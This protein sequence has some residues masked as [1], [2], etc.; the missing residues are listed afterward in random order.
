MTGYGTLVARRVVA[1]WLIDNPDLPVPDDYGP[2][3]IDELV[4]RH[5]AEAAAY[6]APVLRVTEPLRFTP[7]GDTTWQATLHYD[8]AT[9]DPSSFVKIVNVEV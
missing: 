1:G 6:L 4:R 7:A 5:L 8:W 9:R 3:I 2:D